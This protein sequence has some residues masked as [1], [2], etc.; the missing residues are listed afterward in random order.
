MRRSERNLVRVMGR[1]RGEPWAIVPGKLDDMIGLLAEHMEGRRDLTAWVL[2]GGEDEEEGP[3]YEVRGHVA[4]VPLS[5]VM[6]RRLSGLELMCGGCDVDRFVGALRAGAAQPGVRGVVLDVDSPGGM[7]TGTPE[8]ADAVG[9]LAAEMPVVAYA[10]R[11]M[12]SAAYWVGCHAGEVFAAR[13]AGVGSVGVICRG[14]DDS[15]AWEAEGRRAEVFASGTQKDRGVP[16]VAWREEHRE[17]VQEMVDGLAGEFAAAVRANRPEVREE[18][19]ATADYWSGTR[20]AELG[21]VDGWADSLADL[22]REMNGR[23]GG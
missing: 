1:L 3:G 20:A 11:Q 7:V 13:S 17:A 9:E 22:V 18:V 23:L 2:D 6:G 15:A 14:L 16:G 8:T 4:V 19:F 21:L 5:G 12:Y 10:E